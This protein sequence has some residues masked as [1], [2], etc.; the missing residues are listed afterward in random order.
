MGGIAELEGQGVDLS[1]TMRVGS[2]GMRMGCR[3][4]GLRSDEWNDC[5]DN[6][7]GVA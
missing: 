4:S 7:D 6:D 1:L 2:K 5:D 3:E